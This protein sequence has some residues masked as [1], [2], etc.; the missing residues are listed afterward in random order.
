MRDTGHGRYMKERAK[1]TLSSEEWLAAIDIMISIVNA[2]QK[3]T[4]KEVN[5]LLRHKTLVKQM[6]D[7]GAQWSKYDKL[8][9]KWVGANTSRSYAAARADLML[10]CGV[11][12]NPQK[13]R[14]AG[15][16]TP[17][18]QR[19]YKN[20]GVGHIPTSYCIAYHKRGSCTNNQ[21]TYRHSCPKCERNHSLAKGCYGKLPGQ[22]SK[23]DAPGNK[24]GNGVPRHFQQHPGIQSGQKQGQPWKN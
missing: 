20:N 10:S 8:F 24:F 12:S 19:N 21:C 4:K 9:R 14:G 7:N 23:R 1:K 11:F 22:P 13:Q 3:C 2:M 18:Y 5:G 6:Q 17:T 15:S 16:H